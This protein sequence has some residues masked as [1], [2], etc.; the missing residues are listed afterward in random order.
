MGLLRAIL[1]STSHCPRSLSPS[2]WSSVNIL[3]TNPVCFFPHPRYLENLFSFRIIRGTTSN[4]D[5]KWRTAPFG[6]FL[7]QFCEMA[8]IVENFPQFG[9]GN[10]KISQSSDLLG[11][12]FWGSGLFS[13]KLPKIAVSFPRGR[14]G[15]GSG[16]NI[17]EFYRSS[18]SLNFSSTLMSDRIPRQSVSG[19]VLIQNACRI[20]TVHDF[21]ILA[22]KAYDSH[23][24]AL[25]QRVLNDC[26]RFQMITL[27]VS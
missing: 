9:E 18:C 8:K 3:T 22:R 1:R 20:K 24:E 4:L 23:L 6:F 11:N 15:G 2:F 16:Q 27:H 5:E 19:T 25:N 26:F 12:L 7:P 17:D 14:G 21:T 13:S 10:N